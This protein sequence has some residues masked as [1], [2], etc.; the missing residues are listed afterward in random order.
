[1]SGHSK[2]ANIKRTKGKTDAERAKVFTKIGR[3]ISVAAKGGADPNS[4]SKLRDVIEKAKKSN[5]PNDS[6]QRAI[7]RASENN[8]ANYEEVIYE[9]YGTKGVA[10]LVC[11]LTDN[12]NRTAGEVRAA[13][14]KFGNGL[15]TPN[16]VAFMFNKIGEII[17]DKTATTEDELFEI[18]T[19]AGA[20]NM[21]TDDDGN[22]RITTSTSAFDSV[23]KALNDAKIN[24]DGDIVYCSDVKIDLSDEDWESLE[25]LL[26]KLDESDDVQNVYHNAR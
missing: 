15:G 22:F 9:G 7:K 6:I 26:D 18:I 17:V 21:E 5:M 8:M 16:S 4:N 3:E 1:M 25:K 11:A 2:W 12:R 23:C 14:D 24:F 19:E 10:L 13:F 20:D